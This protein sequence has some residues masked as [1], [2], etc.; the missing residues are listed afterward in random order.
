M[1]HTKTLVE[2]VNVF[3]RL[4]NEPILD[5]GNLSKADVALLLEQIESKLSPENLTMDGELSRAKVA[6]RSK[7]LVGARGELEILAAR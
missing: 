7:M 6:R 1:R 2:E 3:R 4:F 5:A